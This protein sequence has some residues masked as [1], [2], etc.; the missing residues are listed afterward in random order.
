MYCTVP[1]PL[2]FPRPPSTTL[3]CLASLYLPSAP[4]LAS[5]RSLPSL[6][7]P[8]HKQAVHGVGERGALFLLQ[9][10]LVP[11]FSSLGPFCPYSPLPCVLP[12]LGLSCPPL[13][14]C[15]CCFGHSLL[16]ASVMAEAELSQAQ[17]V[18]GEW[19]LF[20]LVLSDGAFSFGGTHSTGTE[21]VQCGRS[22]LFYA[23]LANCSLSF[24]FTLSPEPKIHFPVLS[25]FLSYHGTVFLSY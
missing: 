20:P 1:S 15:A 19:P 18:S 23:L 10:A 2:L 22:D 13:A 9:V 3:A 12:C 8:E 17:F 11:P 24:T 7:L 14:A 6:S 21:S 4:C 5:L 25:L 16:L